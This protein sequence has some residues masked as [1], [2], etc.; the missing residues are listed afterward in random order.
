MQ[1]AARGKLRT[2][3]D[4][5]SALAAWHKEAK[6]AWQERKEKEAR[7]RMA[8]LREHDF[9]AYL[10]AVQSEKSAVVTSLLDSTDRCLRGLLGRMPA[11]VKEA[12][13]SALAPAHAAKG[14]SQRAA[15]A[16]TTVGTSSE[17]RLHGPG[18]RV[19]V[20]WCCLL[21]RARRRRPAQEQQSMGV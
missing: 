18:F 11:N 3:V 21:R 9:D 2:P 13:S 14:Q 16:T 8:L 15:E 1:M 20:L 12:V 7:A 5:E 19:G 10:Q 17:S 6:A 4:R